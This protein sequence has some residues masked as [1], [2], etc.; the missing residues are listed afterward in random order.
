MCQFGQKECH[1]LGHVVSQGCVKPEE[2]K[3]A[4]VKEYPRP[5]TKKDV[6]AF[7]GLAGY[8]RRYIPNFAEI[9]TPLTN[10]TKKK[11]LNRVVWTP[12]HQQ[13]FVQ[14]K[15]L[16]TSKPILHSPD[17]EKSFILQTDASETGIGAV[18]SQS[19][20]EGDERPVA[21][22]SRK[23]LPRETRYATVEKECLA[24]VSGVKFFMEGTKFTVETDHRS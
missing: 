19:D 20:A 16:L 21:Y 22:Y 12:M 10:L 24:V 6:R 5:E 11:M 13:A 4:A 8:Y 9:A 23:L 18:L 15:N 7:L 14:L 2:C 1:F 3:I 17:M